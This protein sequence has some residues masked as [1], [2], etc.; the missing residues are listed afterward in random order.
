MEF[1]KYNSI[2][3]S[4]DDEFVQ[5]I[6]MLN[7]DEKECWWCITEKIHGSN[8]SICY[9]HINNTIHY[10]KRTAFLEKGEKCYNV[11]ECFIGMDEKIKQIHAMYTKEHGVAPDSI[12]IFG[13]ICGGSYPHPDVPRDTHASKVQK[14]VYYSNTNKWVAFDI[15]IKLPNQEHYTYYSSKQFFDTCEQLGIQAVPLLAIVRT[16]N[17]ALEYPNNQKSVMYRH[18]GLPKLEDNIMEGVVIRPFKTDVFMGQSRVILKNKNDKFKEKSREKRPDI[19]KDIPEDVAKV[20]AELETYVTENRVYNVLSHFGEMSKSEK[21]QKLGMLIAETNKDI[22]SEA[23][24]DG[25]FN[26]LQN[27]KG[28]F[29]MVTKSLNSQ[30]ANLVKKIILS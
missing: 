30:V 15:A 24:R 3:N 23:E 22:I 17:E 29:K 27:R 19:Y 13:E 14:G 10:G 12:I 20:K 18:F 9:D 11:Q 8:T 25:V 28:D 5:K 1:K 26:I 4:Y 21:I 16:L 6:K 2:V 7:L